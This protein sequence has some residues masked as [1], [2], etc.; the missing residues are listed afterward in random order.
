[1]K[2]HRIRMTHNL[3]LHYGLH[4]NLEVY[5]PQP[6]SDPDLTRF[7]SDDY[8]DFIKNVTPDAQHDFLKQVFELFFSLSIKFSHE[9]E[10]KKSVHKDF[11][12]VC[13]RSLGLQI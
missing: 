10:R 12:S 8:I 1:M 2:P 6:A 13:E 11:P 7:H 9:R 4:K 5:R 3:L